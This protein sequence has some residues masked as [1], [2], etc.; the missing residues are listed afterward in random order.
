M[1]VEKGKGL[2]IDREGQFREIAPAALQ[3]MVY[4]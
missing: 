4:G 2:W 1:F 3:G